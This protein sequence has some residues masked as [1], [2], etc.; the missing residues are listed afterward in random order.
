VVGNTVDLVE[1]SVTNGRAANPMT[2]TDRT[3]A[4]VPAGIASVERERLDRHFPPLWARVRKRAGLP[5]ESMKDISSR[6]PTR[7][8][9]KVESPALQGF[10]RRKSPLTC[11]G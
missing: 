9:A 5:S 6:Q 4:R 1:S 2:S 3:L 10:T 11:G 8:L 7:S